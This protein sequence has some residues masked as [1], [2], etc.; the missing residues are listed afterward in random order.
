MKATVEKYTFSSWQALGALALGALVV[1]FGCA[2]ERETPWK[3]GD[4]SVDQQE[5]ELLADESEAVRHA[6]I[7]MLED[8]WPTVI[9][10]ALT[11]AETSVANLKTTTGTWATDSGSETARTA[12]QEAWTEAMRAWQALEVMQVGPA[13]SSL[14]AVGG[15]NIRDSIYS[16]PTT[17]PCRIDQVTCRFEF[18][19][20]DFFEDALVNAYGLDALETVLFSA[21]NENSCSSNSGINREDTWDN[22]GADGIAQARADYADLM[23][24]KI[25]SDLQRIRHAWESSFGTELATAGQGSEAFDSSV[26]GVN[27]IYDGL[28]YLETFVKDRKLGWPLGIRDCGQEDCSGEV[29]SLMA[30]LSNEWLASNLNGFR[31]LYTGGEGI[32]M[33]DLLVSLEE[34]ALADDV[35]TRLDEADV[36]VAALSSDINETL[37]SDP[38]TVDAAHAAIKEVTDLLKV[39]IATVL[40][41]EVPSE[42]AGDND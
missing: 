31:A 38:D 27:A 8:A 10:P 9:E 28:F 12:A 17:N 21:P 11:L 30:G 18:E 5:D 6:L 2:V 35:L 32:G 36:A 16:W 42:A 4:E 37:S 7:G 1:E 22:V 40:S 41:L 3:D 14:T 25:A 29:E 39:D 13:G 34:E 15:E 19:D 23:A 26:K 33:Y 24:G 20:G